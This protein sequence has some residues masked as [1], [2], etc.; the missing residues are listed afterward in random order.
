VCVCVEVVRHLARSLARSFTRAL[1]F[2][3]LPFVFG[4]FGCEYTQYL[5]FVLSVVRLLML[6]FVSWV[7]V[8]A[9]QLRF[10]PNP[11]YVRNSGFLYFIETEFH[12]VSLLC[13]VSLSLSL[14]LSCLRRLSCPS[15]VRAANVSN[16]VLIF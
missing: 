5:S 6:S 3:L 2:F 9:S 14:S 13:S 11:L 7:F 1:P 10:P 12:W 15:L 4:F 8:V 16:F